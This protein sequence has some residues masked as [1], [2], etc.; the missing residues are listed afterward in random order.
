MIT[1][2]RFE[3]NTV[4]INMPEQKILSQVCS[5]RQ[6]TILQLVKDTGTPDCY[7]TITPRLTLLQ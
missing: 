5:E 2:G 3:T 4:E 1:D 7:T 6:K